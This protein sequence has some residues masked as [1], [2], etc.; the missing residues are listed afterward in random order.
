M[1]RSFGTV[2]LSV[3]HYDIIVDYL[4]LLSIN[5]IKLFAF[6]FTKQHTNIV[7]LGAPS[8]Y[9][10]LHWVSNAYSGSHQY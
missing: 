10:P 9:V 3:I 5:A 2:L 6:F 1:L 8:Q 4:L 7:Q